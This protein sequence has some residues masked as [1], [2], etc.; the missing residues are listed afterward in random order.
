MTE[1]QKEQLE[2]Y[3]EHM[4]YSSRH[5]I[6]ALQSVINN[7]QVLLDPLDGIAYSFVANEPEDIW[8][9]IYR[10]KDQMPFVGYLIEELKEDD[11]G[12][13]Q[14][15]D[16]QYNTLPERQ[17]VEF[18]YNEYFDQPVEMVF[19]PEQVT[20]QYARENFRLKFE[21]EHIGYPCAIQW[22]GEDTFDFGGG[23]SKRLC[24]VIPL[25]NRDKYFIQA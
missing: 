4:R 3:Q 13:D 19:Y 7:E 10:F 24:S 16:D 23:I 5:P 20:E 2:A 15:N 25:T 21:F 9:F 8:R 1:F 6:E 14:L 17:Y 11:V 18:R 22:I 12:F